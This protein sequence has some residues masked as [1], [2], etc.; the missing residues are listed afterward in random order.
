ML[1]LQIGSGQGYGV[2]A[3]DVAHNALQIPLPGFFGNTSE[4]YIFS[5]PGK[6]LGSS[7]FQ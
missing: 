3:C 4:P 6:P 1:C 2:M 7:T 5:V